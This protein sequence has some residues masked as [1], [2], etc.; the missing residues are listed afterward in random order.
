[1]K[2]K[3][4]KN[5]ASSYRATFHLHLGYVLQCT[6]RLQVSVVVCEEVGHKPSIVPTLS[7]VLRNHSGF[8]EDCTFCVERNINELF[9]V[10]ECSS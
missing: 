4:S 6:S 10:H 8:T 2:K 1:M 3:K 5:K 9:E 7:F